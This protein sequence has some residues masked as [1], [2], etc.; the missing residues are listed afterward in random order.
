MNMNFSELFSFSS[1]VHFVNKITCIKGQNFI[2]VNFF[3][4]FNSTEVKL[5]VKHEDT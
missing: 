4:I 3:S 5:A 1:S 2:I